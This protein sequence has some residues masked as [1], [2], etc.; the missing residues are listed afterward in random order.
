MI[1]VDLNSHSSASPPSRNKKN[2]QEREISSV[3]MPAA[4]GKSESRWSEAV[5][6][7]LHA[8][9]FGSRWGAQ[10]NSSHHATHE[11]KVEFVVLEKRRAKH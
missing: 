6:L 5:G 7:C 4:V 10:R 1:T 3:R 2:Y 11:S 8:N 9:R